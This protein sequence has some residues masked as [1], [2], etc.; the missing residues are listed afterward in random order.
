MPVA[1][2]TPAQIIN[3][4]PFSYSVGAEL[5]GDAGLN[6]DLEVICLML[7]TLQCAGISNI[8][9]DLGHVGIYRALVEQADLSDE[10]EQLL[11]EALQRKASADIDA[12]IARG[13]ADELQADRLRALSNLNG[14]LSILA[15]AKMVLAGASP[16]IDDA[17][18]ALEQIAD[19]IAARMP[20]VALYFDLSELRGFHYHTGLVFSALVPG[21]GQ[22]VANGGRYDDIGE[23]FGRARPATGFATDLKALMGYLPM[24]QLAKSDAVYAPCSKGLSAS[25]ELSLWRAVKVLRASGESVV[26]GLSND[27]ESGQYSRSLSLDNG[28]WI[29][30]G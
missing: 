12:A 17:I 21:H 6:S 5:Y 24:D 16:L 9:L 29:V 19:Q 26:C 15:E 27:A 8:T 22:A 30:K 14:D 28:Q 10:S 11:F 4:F 1:C 23:V 18:T 3:G 2:F 20:D 25:D 7:E 13:V